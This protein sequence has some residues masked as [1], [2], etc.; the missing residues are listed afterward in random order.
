MLRLQMLIRIFAPQD[1]RISLG[2]RVEGQKALQALPGPPVPL[3]PFTSVPVSYPSIASSIAASM[4]RLSDDLWELSTLVRIF[5][6]RRVPNLVIYS[7][8]VTFCSWFPAQGPSATTE[9]AG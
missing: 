8:V 6:M 1:L 2:L 7:V 3:L 9:C 4:I 5:I